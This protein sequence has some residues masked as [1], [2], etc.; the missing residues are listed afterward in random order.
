VAVVATTFLAATV[1]ISPVLVSCRS[2]SPGPTGGSD[3]ST[4]VAPNT[5][6]LAGD[7]PAALQRDFDLMASTGAGWVRF[8]FDWGGAEPE[9]GSFNWARIDRLVGA[10]RARRLRV[11][12]TVAYT[13]AWARP[14]GTTDKVTSPS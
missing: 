10:A 11:L 9:P 13:P 5:A 8:D 12:A 14:Q 1:L 7:S 2:S 3:E 6:L 4:G